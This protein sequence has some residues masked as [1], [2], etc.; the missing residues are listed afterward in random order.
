VI[1]RVK[2]PLH[3]IVHSTDQEGIGQSSQ[4]WI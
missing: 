1:D 2:N 4:P 3:R